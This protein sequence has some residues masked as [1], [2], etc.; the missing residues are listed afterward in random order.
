MVKRK[1]GPSLLYCAIKFRIWT[2]I[3]DKINIR[4]LFLFE[5]LIFQYLCYQ[6]IIALLIWFYAYCFLKE[7][8]WFLS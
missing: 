5:K 4:I 3:N 7:C 2:K 1:D 8:N 6:D